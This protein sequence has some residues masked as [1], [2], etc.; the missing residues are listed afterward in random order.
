MNLKKENQKNDK[1]EEEEEDSFIKKKENRIMGKSIWTKHV[2]I[3]Y[4]NNLGR[5]SFKKNSQKFRTIRL[6]KNF[7]NNGKKI[8]N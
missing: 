3:I 4:K 6:E 8:W 7:Y 1:K 5:F 2:I